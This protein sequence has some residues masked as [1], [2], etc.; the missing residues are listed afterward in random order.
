MKMPSI[1]KKLLYGQISKTL[2]D[3]IERIR[4]KYTAQRQQQIEGHQNRTWADWLNF[5]AENGD[6]DA[7]TALR[8]QNRKNKGKYSLS[9][10]RA[11]TSPT[12]LNILDSITKEGTEIYKFDKAVIRNNGHE[13]KNF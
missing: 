11:D 5:K 7:L 1:Q 9:G 4:N 12:D 6:G 8:F 13:I 2:L 10:G 3:E